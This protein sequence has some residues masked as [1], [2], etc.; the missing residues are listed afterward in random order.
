M[1]PPASPK[2]TVRKIQSDAKNYHAERPTS[3]QDAKV[4]D[5]LHRNLAARPSFPQPRKLLWQTFRFPVP[6][7]PNLF[8]NQRA[9]LGSA[10]PFCW[11]NSRPNRLSKFE[12][13]PTTVYGKQCLRKLHAPEQAAKSPSIFVH[14]D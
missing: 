14:C 5:L 13:R 3:R 10:A 1:N 11:K 6:K 4:L 2:A 9:V 8:V 7:F 12:L